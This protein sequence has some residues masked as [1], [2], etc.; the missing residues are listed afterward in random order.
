METREEFIEEYNKCREEWAGMLVKSELPLFS[1]AINEEVERRSLMRKFFTVE[2]IES[3]SSANYPLPE[4]L[5]TPVWILPGMGYVA[6][7]YLE[8]MADEVSIPVFTVQV[9]KEWLLKYDQEKR[10]D[11][12]IQGIKSAAKVLSEYEEEAA[13][14]TIFP[15]I[16]SGFDG[17]GV[18]LPRP[19][20]IYQ[21][22][23]ADPAAGYFSKELVNRLIVGAAR[24]GHKLTEI[25]LSPEDLADI[26]EWTD[27][28]VDPHTRAMIFQA[29]GNLGELWGIKLTEL[30]QLGIRGRYNINDKTSQYGPFSGSSTKNAFN[31]YHITHGNVMDEN[32]NLVIAGETQIIGLCEGYQEQLRMPF[33]PYEAHYDWTLL[34]KQRT[35]FFGWQKFGMGCLDAR[36][37][38]MGVIDRYVPSFN[39]DRSSR[40]VRSIE[41]S[42]VSAMVD[43]L[44]RR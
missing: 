19:A 44:Y 13:W 9:A 22:P 1:K 25:L 31:G 12:V 2:Q 34:R 28:D 42:F 14:R 10:V 17:A 23:S 32:G 15:A 11:I 33:I 7:D 24:T 21:M 35:G 27:M 41:N 4:D 18:L 20:P 37:L 8:L 38:L 39:E 26:R 43:L 36:Y 29:K 30:D 5:E 16:T 6:Q 40:S 3:G